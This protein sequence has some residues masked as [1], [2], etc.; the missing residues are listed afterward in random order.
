MSCCLAAE[1]VRFCQYVCASRSSLSLSKSFLKRRINS[2]IGK[3]VDKKTIPI[4][5]GLTT[6]DKSKPIRYQR[7]LSGRN[8][9]TQ[10]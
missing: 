8:G 3:I 6:W 4:I 9:A 5:R 10:K 2:P 1:G 7:L